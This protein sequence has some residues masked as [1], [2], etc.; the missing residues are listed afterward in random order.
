LQAKVIDSKGET[1]SLPAAIAIIVVLDV[2]LIGFLAWMMSHPR[3]LTPHV[4]ANDVA[5]PKP[6]IEQ[7]VM[8]TTHG[9]PAATRTAAIELN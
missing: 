9:H 8:H 5:T 7:R 3:H 6:S 1:V 4:S 2:A